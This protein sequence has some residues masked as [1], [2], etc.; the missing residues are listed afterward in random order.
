MKTGEYIL[1]RNGGIKMREALGMVVF[2]AGIILALYVGAWCLFIQPIIGCCVAFDAGTLTGLM[3]GM[4]IIKC[5]FASAVGWITFY[6]TTIIAR[7][8]SG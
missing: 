2:V 8:I 1:I 4:T 5:V 6:I 3:V 7:I